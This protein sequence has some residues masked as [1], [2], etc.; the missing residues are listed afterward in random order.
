MKERRWR[1]AAL[2]VAVVLVVLG[3]GVYVLTTRAVELGIRAQ[4]AFLES[5]L[6]EHEAFE[7]DRG[8]VHRYSGG[9]GDV[10]VLIH[11]F[12]DSASGW[13]QVVRTLAEHYRVVTLDLPGHGASDPD[14]P[15]LGFHDLE[16]GLDAVLRNEG[17]RLILLGSSLGGWLA[18]RFAIDHPERVRRLLLLN[19]AGASWV[20][21]GEELLLPR[22]RAQQRAKNRALLG[23]KA[24]PA[25]D[26]LLDQL[27]EHGRRPRLQSLWVEQQGHFLDEQLPELRIPVDM[28]WGTPDP[29]FPIDSYAERLLETL[30]DARLHR[31]DGCGHA[32][33]YSCPDLLTELVLELLAPDD[34][35]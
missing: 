13:S 24:P 20:E 25:P 30:P 34:S 29:F 22:T 5:V 12:G 19:A 14:A 27:I 17:D 35:E 11:G 33:Q 2:I 6:S 16:A 18:T 26:F 1:I 21:H 4:Q 10:L 7:T 3:S 23:T 28:L 15:P 8:V 9:E 31:L 32:P